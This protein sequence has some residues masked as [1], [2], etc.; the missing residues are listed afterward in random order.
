MQFMIPKLVVLHLKHINFLQTAFRYT[1]YRQHQVRQ[2][3]RSSRNEQSALIESHLKPSMLHHN[4]ASNFRQNLY[5]LKSCLLLIGVSKLAW[6]DTPT[7]DE[8]ILPFVNAYCVHCHG[9]D[10]QQGEFRIDT[11]AHD[12]NTE[13]GAQRWAAV[14]ERINAGEMP[15]KD[16]RQ[17]SG[18]ELE[19]VVSWLH[20]KIH[21]GERVRLA[22]RGPI[23]YYRLSRE[24]YAN[25]IQD[26]LGVHFDPMAPGGFSADPEWH[27]FE[28]IGSQLSLSP[29]H[30]EKYF[31]AGE[32][33]LNQ[34]YPDREVKV[35]HARK[36]ALDIDWPNEKK[37]KLLEEIGVA[38][39]IRTLIWPGHQLTNLNPVYRLEDPGIYR[40][41]LRLSGLAPAQG[42]V[43]HVAIYLKTLEKMIFETD[44]L[45]PENEPVTLEFEAYLPAGRM[46]ISI[47]NEVPGPSNLGRC[48]Q[49]S[50]FVFTTFDD[51]KSRAP[52]QRKMTDDEGR[53]LYPVL[54]FDSLD[55]EGP[56]T[57]EE[58]Q[59]KRSR[60]LPAEDGNLT[61]ARECLTRLAE[62][63]WRRPVTDEEVDRYLKIV[64][65]QIQ[66]GA[67]FRT[68]MKTGMLG[69]LVSQNFCYLTEG[70]PDHA[71]AQL[72]DWELASRLSYFLWSS[73]P[74]EEL[75]EAARSG[76]LHQPD[77]L[78]KQLRRMLV[79]PRITRF[80]DSFPRQWLQLKRV[81]M[82]PPDV[83]L[84]PDYDP[85]LEKSMVLET[86]SFFRE[87]FQANLS[88]A[89]FLDSNWSVMNP[90]LALHYG[91]PALPESG[92]QRVTLEP[93]L[94]RGG[95]L[96]QASVLS[97][98][99]DGTRVRP[100]HRGVWISESI[101]G[102]TPQPPPPNIEPIE[103]TPLNEPKA[104]IRQKLEAHT[105][106]ASC[107]SCHKRIDPLGFAFNH[108][109]AIGRWQE[110]EQVATGTGDSPPVDASGS[111]L[112]GRSFD[113]ADEFKKILMSDIDTFGEAFIEKLATYGLRRPMSLDDRDQLLQISHLCQT[114]HYRLQDV[115]E[116]LVLS[117]LFR[118]R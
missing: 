99:S 74:D 85:W 96:T 19:R 66:A 53:P 52:W 118:K 45:A 39:R 90:R 36:D 28:R 50:N 79:D 35:I 114:D 63:A 56:I 98:T 97:L 115:I 57:T 84:Y 77:Q 62:H 8:T 89:E 87:V 5:L 92:F 95:I 24:E 17:P 86:T 55:W 78:R 110:T 80:T 101:F 4:T 105:T 103:P 58:D 107:A 91:L 29:A 18:K 109:D 82:F 76:T 72:N 113:G 13:Q 33:I 106:N 112:D 93:E 34:A 16:E 100:V 102:K 32:M 7:F 38:E 26:L 83:K 88:I 61:Q 15:P 111:F 30:V 22:Q 27:G 40:A 117:D 42:R 65:T 69:I 47:N 67:S 59:R 71:R 48:G 11:L 6:A 37:R 51:P 20:A 104:T 108:Y 14:M 68:A 75:M 116:R 44:V 2:P 46:D 1:E 81:G 3:H 60:F 73:L 12:F 49:P 25:S 31:A 43:P 10:D 70:S 64:E 94:H 9:A 41:R 23:E 21:E 54:I